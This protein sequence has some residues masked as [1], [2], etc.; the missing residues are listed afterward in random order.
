MTRIYCIICLLITLTTAV[1]QEGI[2]GTVDNYTSG[3]AEIYSGIKTPIKIGTID[4]NGTFQIPLDNTYK[5]Q[6]ISSVDADNA[7]DSQ[8]KTS[9]PNLERSYGS[10]YNGELDIKGGDQTMIALSQLGV[11]SVANFEE[12]KLY[13]KIMYA[14]DLE[15]AK[16]I[17]S[18]GQFKVKKGYQLDWY[19]FESEA[20]VKGSCSLEFYPSGD[21]TSF[22]QTS[23]YDLEFKPG[24]NLVK[25]EIEEVFTDES[26]KE[27]IMKD[28]SMVL[29]SLPDDVQIIFL[30]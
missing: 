20:S 12:Q 29:D 3:E 25:Y 9:L 8:W 30:E 4:E 27:Y 13:G 5:D 2:E 16:A 6:L 21:E 17:M 18:F 7:K 26:G 14:S 10:C 23:N 22:T 15:F 1:S 11:F 24:W 19:Y 28:H